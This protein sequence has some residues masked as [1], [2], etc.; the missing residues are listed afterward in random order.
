MQSSSF[1]KR[2]ETPQSPI[3]S[4]PDIRWAAAWSCISVEYRNLDHALILLVPN[5]CLGQNLALVTPQIVHSRRWPNI[6]WTW[7]LL[8]HGNEL[9]GTLA[10]KFTIINY[11]T[12]VVRVILP[13]LRSPWGSLQPTSSSR[14]PNWWEPLKPHYSSG[15]SCLI[16]RDQQW[17]KSRC[18]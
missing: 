7:D 10:V 6:K 3:Q 17:S 9:M 18:C 1:N 13:I 5:E 11:N 14:L 8:R 16:T 2:L 15:L 12:G 4:A